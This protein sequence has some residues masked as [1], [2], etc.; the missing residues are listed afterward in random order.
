[1]TTEDERTLEELARLAQKGDRDAARELLL[2]RTLPWIEQRL[3]VVQY[4]SRDVQDIAFRALE[5]IAAG[6]P[7]YDPERSFK[8]WAG[9]IINN[10]H[11]SFLRRVMPRAA[12]QDR[13]DLLHSADVRTGS[14]DNAEQVAFIVAF[15]ACCAQ[16]ASD[17]RRY[18]MWSHIVGGQTITDLE[19][20]HPAH[21][22]SI[23]RWIQRDLKTVYQCV[24][25][26]LPPLK[27]EP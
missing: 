24:Y 14:D 26:K 18:L 19:R 7:S 15:R 9:T 11:R 6:L 23:R 17:V 16:L 10:E 8:A 4:D 27:E 13:W 20:E 22:H 2:R 1:M 3:A 25:P 12:A 5:K 21:R